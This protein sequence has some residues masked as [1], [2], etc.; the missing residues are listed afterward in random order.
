MLRFLLRARFALILAIAI[1]AQAQS[2][3]DLPTTRLTQPGT[4][5]AVGTRPSV[6]LA[7]IAS[8]FPKTGPL[9]Q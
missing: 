8:A 6:S 1:P 7:N 2:V 4:S 5:Q 9:A 3:I